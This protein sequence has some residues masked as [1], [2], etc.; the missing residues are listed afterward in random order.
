MRKRF[1]LAVI[2]AGLPLGCDVTPAKFHDPID[3]T[4][5]VT[6]AD[7]T[8]VKNVILHFQ[9]TGDGVMAKF[10]VGA[11][12]TFRGQL[13]PGRY[14]Y[15]LG[16]REGD[17]GADDRNNEAALLVVPAQFRE[18]SLDRQITVKPSDTKLDIKLR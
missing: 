17:T 15:Y 6:L 1:Y 13:T 14:T 2:L 4:G 7:G 10:P 9:P 18:G 5:S 16:S 11:D 8:L 12:G 3:V